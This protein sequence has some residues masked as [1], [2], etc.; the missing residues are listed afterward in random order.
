MQKRVTLTLPRLL[1]QIHIFP[2]LSL[3]FELILLTKPDAHLLA[4]M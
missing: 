3:K 4:N 2:R 1:A